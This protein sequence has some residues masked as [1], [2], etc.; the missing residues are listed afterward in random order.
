MPFQYYGFVPFMFHTSRIL[1]PKVFLIGIKDFVEALIGLSFSRFT[2]LDTP[3][4]FHP[5]H[6]SALKMLGLFCFCVYFHCFV[7]LSTLITV[8]RGFFARSGCPGATL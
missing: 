5:V 6:H 4:A 1:Y 3:A 2:V 8:G 7:I